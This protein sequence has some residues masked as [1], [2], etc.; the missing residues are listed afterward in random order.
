MGIND[1]V[2]SQTLAGEDHVFLSEKQNKKGGDKIQR[3]LKQ[4]NAQIVKC[5]MLLS[6]PQTLGSKYTN[7][8]PAYTP[9]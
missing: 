1:N 6:G 4:K 7:L 2:R 3:Y 8:L 9:H 5:L